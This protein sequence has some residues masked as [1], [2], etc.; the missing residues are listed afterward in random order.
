MSAPTRLFLEH[1]AIDGQFHVNDKDGF[2]FGQGHEIPD[3][4]QH[5]RIVSDAP[6]DFG[7]SYE[8]FTRICVTERPEGTF[9][10]KEAFIAALA[11]IAGMHV[12]K[13]FDDNMHFLGYTMELRE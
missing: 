9:L 5:A 4:I 6:I 2:A 13:V 12:T 11:D 10:D 7:D 3:A 8:G 1:N